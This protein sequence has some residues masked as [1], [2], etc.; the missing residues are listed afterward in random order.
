MSPKLAMAPP[1]P[2][3]LIADQLGGLLS[4]VESEL[5]PASAPTGESQLAD[6]IIEVIRQRSNEVSLLAKDVAEA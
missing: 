3:R 6:R 2:A 4:L 1:L 5:F